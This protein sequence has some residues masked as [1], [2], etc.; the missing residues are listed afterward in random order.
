MYSELKSVSF[1]GVSDP[2]EMFLSEKDLNAM[3][4]NFL[5]RPTLEIHHHECQISR[6]EGEEDDEV[7]QVVDQDQ[8][9]VAVQEE[10]QEEDK[11]DLLASTLKLKIPTVEEFKVVEDDDSG[12]KT[13]TSLD[14]KIPVP[15]KCPPAPRKPKSLPSS[16]M[17]RKAH[18]HRRV[19]LDLSS[20]IES[21]FPPALVADF[22]GKI[23]KKFRQ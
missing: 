22:G 9:V 4:F 3:E 7:S 12:F 14:K 8:E 21:L 5:V 20:E 19:F 10:K 6:T 17:K 11:F 16:T 1:M 13:P 18:R 2:A 15:L 23:K